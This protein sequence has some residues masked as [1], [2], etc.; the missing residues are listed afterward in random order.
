M[1]WPKFWTKTSAWQTYALS[2]L[3]SLVCFIASK[4]LDSFIQNPPAKIS[5]AK[6]IVVGNIVVGG[7]GKTPFILWL[8]Q[9]LDKQQISYGIVSRG[10]GGKSVEYPLLV[11]KDSKP[12]QVG[13]EPILYAKQLN[14]PIVVSPDRVAAIELLT[15]YDL[16]LI[17]ADD[18]L[19][20]YAMARDVEIIVFDGQ[21]GI[22]NGLCMPAGPLRESHLRI[23][24]AKF[25]VCNGSC[26]DEK[27]NN[28]VTAKIN[29]MTL[30]PTIFKRVNNPSV[31]LS[32][33]SFA[34]QKVQAIAAIGN[35]QR[36]YNSLQKLAIE[37]TTKDFADHKNYQLTDFSWLDKTKP[38]L[39]TEKDAVKCSS[40]ASDNWWYL[41]IQP[42]CSNQLYTNIIKDC[43]NGR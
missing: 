38:L 36:F 8:A 23:K 20:H 33:D 12:E 40:F 3:A 37:V 14:C 1:S 2:P 10:Y 42:V 34:G 24:N 32:L 29:L 7:S 6:V 16:E 18:G 43:F 39:M 15:S 25:I 9:Q 30:N 17:I 21:R 4:R 28:L 11:T 35:P 41:V 13:D 5:S 22:G 27:I 31:T 26:E 19:Q